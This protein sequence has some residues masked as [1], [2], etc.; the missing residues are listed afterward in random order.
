VVAIL[1][2]ATTILVI[3]GRTTTLPPVSAPPVITLTW[4]PVGKDVEPWSG[5]GLGEQV[6]RALNARGIVVVDDTRSRTDANYVLEGTVGRKGK[7]SEIGMQLVRVQD[8]VAVWASTFW[9]DPND[10]ESLASDLAGAVAQVLKAETSPGSE[11][12]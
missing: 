5:L 6:R 7:R 4:H 9:R 1:T 11:P 2:L 10:L 3:R 8:G 12:P